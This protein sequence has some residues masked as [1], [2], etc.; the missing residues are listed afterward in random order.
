MTKTE[1]KEIAKKILMESLSVAY[2]RLVD[3]VYTYG[4]LTDNEIEEICQYINKY[5]ESMA[6][7]I[8]RNY[9]TQ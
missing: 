5:G 2:Y 1:K 3:D 9:Y 8:G 7:R 4:K 6:K